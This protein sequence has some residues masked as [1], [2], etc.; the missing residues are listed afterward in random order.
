MF[1]RFV[2]LLE[3][4]RSGPGEADAGRLRGELHAETR[5]LL[6]VL[7]RGMVSAEE[8]EDL[9]Q[10]KV[11]QLADHLITDEVALRAAPSYLRRAA[12][13]EAVSQIRKRKSQREVLYEPADLVDVAQT[14][15]DAEQD[16]IE[17]EQK[18]DRQRARQRLVAALEHPRL[19]DRYRRA[20]REHYI[21][22]KSIEQMAAEELERQPAEK[23]AHGGAE[24]RARNLVDQLLSRARA[25]LRQLARE[26]RP[27]EEGRS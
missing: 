14:S 8:A 27:D 12:R 19:A 5:R 1:E 22:G 6:V 7:V 26:V 15:Q 17:I 11:V 20:L 10:E 16:R 4:A 9:A 18:Q 13:N 21:E 3:K 2:A 25:R 23:R 24:R